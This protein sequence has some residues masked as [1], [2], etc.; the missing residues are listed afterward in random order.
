MLIA[1]LW[2]KIQKCC[3]EAKNEDERSKTTTRGGGWGNTCPSVTLPAM[4]CSRFKC[5][6]NWLLNSFESNKN[7]LVLVFVVL[8]IICQ[9][10]RNIPATHTYMH[11][12][13]KKNI[14]LGFSRFLKVF[15][16][17]L[18]NVFFFFFFL[19]CIIPMLVPQ[20]SLS[21]SKPGSAKP[22]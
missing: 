15:S 5:V 4:F 8:W 14:L 13:V 11:T 2:S 10:K 7:F 21:G 1:K 12:S 16:F 22:D 9:P 20:A 6:W 19:F 17:S 18:C 3:D